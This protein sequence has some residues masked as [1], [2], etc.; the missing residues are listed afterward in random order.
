MKLIFLILFFCLALSVYGEENY[1]NYAMFAQNAER[2]KPVE[3]IKTELPLK[4]SKNTRIA[5]IGNTL[6]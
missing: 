6:F 3:P 1:Q 2:A 5:L 4:L